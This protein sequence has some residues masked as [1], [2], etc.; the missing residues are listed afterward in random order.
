MDEYIVKKCYNGKGG[1]FYYK[2]GRLHREAGPAI[3][4]PKLKDNNLGDEHLYKEEI[5]TTMNP[6]GYFSQYVVEDCYEH[7]PA[8]YYLEGSGYSKKDFEEIKVKLD[9]KNELSN[10]LSMIQSNNKKV[11][12]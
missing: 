11:K 5:I 10:E 6:Y 12:I 8:K 4:F 9:L 1:F 3:I 2:N 7:T